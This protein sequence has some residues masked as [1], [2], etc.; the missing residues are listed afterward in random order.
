MRY[1]MLLITSLIVITFTTWVSAPMFGYPLNGMSQADI[2]NM[3]PTAITPAGFTF[4]IWSVIYLSWLVIGLIIAKTSITTMTR[5]IFPRLEKLVQSI[6]VSSSMILYYSLAIGITAIWLIPWAYNMIGISLII[7]LVL[8]GVL[9]YAFHLSR[10][11]PP[12]IWW[13]VELFLGWIHIATIANITIWLVSLWFSGGGI[14]EVYWAIGVLGLAVLL[15]LY[16]QYRYNT[17][18]I[19]FVFLWA[20]IGVMAK[21]DT[22]LQQVMVG[23][24]MGVVILSMGHTYLRK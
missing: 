16:Y 9:K 12:V 17:Y 6:N 8:L 2:S 13:G 5:S 1:Y 4:A 22:T 23:I 24:Y 3:Y 14:S 19:S 11:E 21:H 7:M 15:T 18:I 10:K 20:M